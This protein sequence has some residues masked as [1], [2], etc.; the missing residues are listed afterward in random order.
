MKK[1]L[2]TLV[3][4]FSLGFALDAQSL[5]DDYAKMIETQLRI[6]IKSF[7][8]ENLQLTKEEEQK[9]DPMFTKYLG[10]RAEHAMKRLPLLESYIR[11]FDNLSD[12]DLYDFNKKI[13]KVNKEHRKLQNKYYKKFNHAIGTKKTTAYFLLEK[14]ID[15][16]LDYSVLDELFQRITI[17]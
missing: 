15:N 13:L 1:L 2:L 6:E 3:C 9:F 17:D 4:V 16:S 11:Q 5:Y 10:E 7:V 14:Y 8:Y 12:S